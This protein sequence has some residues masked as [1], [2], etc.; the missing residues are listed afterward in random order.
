[1]QGKDAGAWPAVRAVLDPNV[2]GG[3]MV[4]PRVFGL[5]GEPRVEPVRGQLADVALAARVWAESVELTGV[6]PA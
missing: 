4:G 6:E 1:M 5:R 3:Q 2:R